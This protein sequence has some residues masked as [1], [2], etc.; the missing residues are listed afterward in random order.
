VIILE[1]I[2]LYLLIINAVSLLLMHQDKR[3]AIRK[4]WRIPEKTLMMTAVLG[5][6][7]GCLVGIYAFRHKTRHLKFTL[8]VPAILAIQLAAGIWLATR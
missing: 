4:K 1:Y 3:R 7:V 8:G 6:S 5:G 2:A